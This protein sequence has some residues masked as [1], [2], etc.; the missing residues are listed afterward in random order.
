MRQV[1]ITKKFETDW[2]NIVAYI[3]D[4][5]GLIYAV[6][7]TGELEKLFI[8]LSEFPEIGKKNFVDSN[9]RSFVFRQSVL[10]YYFTKEEIIFS[11]VFD[12]RS[13]FNKSVLLQN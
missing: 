6:Q 1:I 10:T 2:D 4:N 7:I 12:S 11:R 3:Q 5:F 9:R 8:T 13:I